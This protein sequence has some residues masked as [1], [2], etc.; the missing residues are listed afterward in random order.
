M[1]PQTAV[2]LHV[3]DDFFDAFPDSVTDDQ[4]QELA[5][6]ES[7]GDG[8]DENVPLHIGVRLGNNLKEA[9]ACE[10]S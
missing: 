3:V 9:T 4:E 1:E 6:L 2:P 5:S 7:A 8:I 10:A